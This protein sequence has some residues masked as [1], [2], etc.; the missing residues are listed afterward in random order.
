MADD[1]R[2]PQVDLQKLAERVAA[3]D[4]SDR[5]RFVKALVASPEIDARLQK[6][7]GLRWV[8]ERTY[9]ETTGP[10]PAAFRIIALL[11]PRRVCEEELGDA[12]EVLD[13]LYRVGAPRWHTRVKVCSTV[14][15]V[16]INGLREIVSA[17]LGR[18]RTKSG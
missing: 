14:F 10:R 3:M 7:P 18:E 16:L 5:K 9:K 1:S 17:A 6:Y 2:P 8:V 12:L 15:W 11:V 4:D 13:H